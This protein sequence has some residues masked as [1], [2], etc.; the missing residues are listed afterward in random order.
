MAAA[1]RNVNRVGPVEDGLVGAG[2]VAGNRPGRARGLALLA[3]AAAAVVL[4]GGYG[5]GWRWTGFAHGVL[6][7]D[8][9][10]VLLLPLAVAVAPLWLRHGHR[11]GR[12]RHVLLE[13]LV[14]GFALLVVLGY[15]MPLGWTGFPGN[16]LWDWLELLVLPLAVVLVPVW[17][18]LSRGVQRVHRVA[19]AAALAL[20]AVALAGG[21]GEGWRWTGFEGNTLF[22]WL[23]LLVAPLL[24]PIV[25]VP[26]VAAWTTA[27]VEDNEAAG[28]GEP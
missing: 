10:H 18:D 20:L 4:W 7:W 21:Y 27:A 26:F 23:Q 28:A 5:R 16:T 14:L 19:G 1:V 8:W 22:D 24:F 12:L 3:L 11:L 13:A 15:V 2:A 6:L 9:L 25:L 17:I